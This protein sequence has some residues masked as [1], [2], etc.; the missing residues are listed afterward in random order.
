MANV[1]DPMWHRGGDEPGGIQ[2]R[3]LRVAA[4]MSLLELAG[5]LDDEGVRIDA[6]HLQR[7]EAGRI[8]RPTAETL[9]AI[10]TAGLDTPFRTRRN[11][12]E[13]FGYRLPWALPT[14]R[15]VEE[16]RRLCAQELRGATWPAYLMDHG[17]RLWQWNRYVPRLLGLAPDD[18]APARFVGLTVLDLVFNPDVGI[19]LLIAN[20]DEYRPLFL[21]MF[22]IQTQP[23]AEEPWFLELLDRAWEWPGF[24]QLWSDLPDDADDVLAT[25]PI[26]PIEFRVPGIAQPLR[27]RIALI[28]LTLDPRFQVV[29]WIP[30][31]AATLRQ[32]ASWAEEDGEG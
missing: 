24:E 13:S 14:E 15:E 20:P 18:P 17:Q 22:K 3:A 8:L 25:Q 6:A 7:I 32:C 28:Y 26:H 27:F 12:L 9:A 5:H 29:H 1:N 4:G 31:G 23:H 30:F 16:G 10:L 21:R 11:V 19:N 2:I